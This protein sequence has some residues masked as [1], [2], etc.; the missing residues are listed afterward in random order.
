MGNEPEKPKNDDNKNKSSK[1]KKKSII[2]KTE[3]IPNTFQLRLN[4]KLDT[5]YFSIHELSFNRI[6]IL[7]KLNLYIY[8]L[9][10]FKQ[11]DIIKMQLPKNLLFKLFDEEKHY[12]DD[13]KKDF[14]ELYNNDIVIWS[15]NLVLFYKF[16]N[17]GYEFYQNIKS[18]Y[19]IN[20]VNELKNR[21][22][23]TCG[24]F[25]LNIYTKKKN[26]YNLLEE[27]PLEKEVIC[28]IEKS[29]NS[30]ILIQ[31]NNILTLYDIEDEEE[32]VKYD[33]YEYSRERPTFAL[34]NNYF[35][36]NFNQE[37]IIF[38]KKNLNLKK[39][40]QGVNFVSDF[41]GD[42]ILIED[43]KM[44]IIKICEYKDEKINFCQVFPFNFENII[45]L[46]NGNLIG[47]ANNQIKVINCIKK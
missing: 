44:N 6:G 13:Q 2:K 31:N 1:P 26:K 8:S 25:G 4:L 43:K 22:L 18:N 24:S 32:K 19:L 30:L 3:E 7:S 10:T 47:I 11:I 5:E 45:K 42:L 28:I 27:H 17:K 41:F 38:D 36:F 20:S 12:E 21:N 23:V 33:G 35:V 34:K 9:K 14:L 16:T 37:C 39:K 15:R 46:S 29:Q 40:I